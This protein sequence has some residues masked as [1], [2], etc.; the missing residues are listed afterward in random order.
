MTPQQSVTKPVLIANQR[1]VNRLKKKKKKKERKKGKKGEKKNTLICSHRSKISNN[2][3]IFHRHCD[4]LGVVMIMLTRLLI[5]LILQVWTMST[6]AC[7]AQ[8]TE[9][10][11]WQAYKHQV[12]QW[13]SL[14][15]DWI[16][17]HKQIEYVP[18][19]RWAFLRQNYVRQLHF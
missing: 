1:R 19:W 15:Q 8:P 13:M 12:T 4:T 10:R 9:Q 16:T 18:W 5:T 7:T 14:T 11:L 17:N 6:Q 2:T 3:N